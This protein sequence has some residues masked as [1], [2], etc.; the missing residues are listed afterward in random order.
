MDLENVIEQ[1]GKD[2]G[3]NRTTLIETLEA[4]ILTAAKKAYGQEREIE[5]QYNDDKGEIELFQI[6]TVNK[7]EDIDNPY[8]EVSVEEIREAG[9]DAEPGDELLFQIFYKD[10]D[11]EKA[12]LQDKRFGDLLKLDSY[13]ATFGRIAA[14]TAKQ[15]I[16]QRVREAE[17][18]MIFDE[19]K[20]RTG[21]VITGVV[22][23]FEKGDI[24]IDLG[25]ADAI[26]PRR[27]QTQ[28]E[29]YRPGDRIQAMIKEVKRSSRGPQILMSRADPQLLIKLF[30]QEVP[31][32]YEDIVQ[33]V[34]VAREAGVRSKVAVYSSDS[35][36]DPVGACVGMQGARVQ[37]VVE[38]LGGEKIDIVP[39]SEDPAKFVTNA[40]SPAE[41]RKV[42][43]DEINQTMELVVPEDQ[44]SLA[45]GRGGQNVRLAAQL[46]GWDLDIVS[47]EELE[48]IKEQTRRMLE[49]FQQ[50]DSTTID[51]LFAVG[52]NRLEHLGNIEAQELAEIPGVSE[53]QA[54]IVT[55]AL[56]E[57]EARADEIDG[58]PITHAEYE[59]GKLQKIRGI[60]EEVA[61]R[62][63][64]AGYRTVDHLL[65]EDEPEIIAEEADITNKKS[66][67][68]WHAAKEHLRDVIGV[69]SEEA[70]E[71]R[72]KAFEADEIAY[73][74]L[75]K[76]VDSSDESDVNTEDAQE[77]SDGDASE[78]D[79][80]KSQDVLQEDE[81]RARG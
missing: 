26:L 19:Y 10:R 30:E 48:E 60:G 43:I 69:D 80:N 21:E 71:A 7:E 45:I 23:R 11:K 24:I 62:L 25:R 14:Q 59:L 42:L 15:V 58:E 70:L 16:I 49:D 65:F 50:I 81:A 5:A 52:Y 72:R 77:H 6:I 64:Q 36:V 51:A 68:I 73:R 12:K 79:D 29:S 38:E 9:F 32:I 34:A 47:Q 66:Q 44:L 35:D 41:V 54:A 75:D 27:E 1:V 4:A 31:E 22:R 63:H 39:Y 78:S 76:D 8:R 33:I 67:Q 74:A 13:N 18:D 40:I 57:I 28:N 55:R 3:I 56:D 20:D 46:T 37:N 53:D 17:R 61:K 2:K